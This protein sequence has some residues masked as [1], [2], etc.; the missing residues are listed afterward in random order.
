MADKYGTTGNDLLLG[1]TSD[2]RLIGKGGLDTLVG[3]S[4]NDYLE[5]GEGN[6]YLAGGAGNDILE[7][8]TGA[9]VLEGGTGDDKYYIDSLSDQIFENAGAGIDSVFL[10]LGSYTMAA[11]LENAY[12][13]FG[14]HSVLT[15]NDLDNAIYMGLG[16]DTVYGGGG[17]DF[18]I[19][20]AGNDVIYGGAGNDVLNGGT[21]NNWLIGGS[22]DDTYFVLDWTVAK[23]ETLYEAANE[24][25]DRV[26][27]QGRG[28]AAS[29]GAAGEVHS[30]VLSN[31]FEELAGDGNFAFNFKGNASDNV[32]QGGAYGDT[33]DGGT[34][35]DKMYGGAGADLYIVDNAGDTIY[36]ETLNYAAMDTARV[37][38]SIEWKVMSGVERV[39]IVVGNAT[40]TG[41]AFDDYIYGSSDNDVVYGGGGNDYI[42]GGGGTDWLA[43]DSGNDTLRTADS[44]NAST[45]SGGTGDDHFY[46]ANSSDLVIELADG[47]S[48]TVHLV[49][50]WV[51]GAEVEVA[52]V[53]STL[54][55][56]VTGN[57]GANLMY[58]GI[59]ADTLNG[60][61][62]NDQL[63]GGTG[64]DVMAGGAGDDSYWITST[65]DLITELAN[66][67]IDTV[68][69]LIS[70]GLTA[71]V[72]NL[73]L[74]WLAT[75]GT[76]NVL[77]NQINGSFGSQT[78]RGMAGAD[79]IT[80]SAGADVLFGGAGADAFVFAFGDNMAQ[81]GQ[82]DTISDFV[83]GKDHID[84]TA[85]DSMA[86]TFLGTGAFTNQLGEMRVEAMT[87]GV[88]LLID[89][90][91]DG[92]AD[93][94]IDLLGLSGLSLNDFML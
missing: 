91:G 83:R 47:G 43:G 78:L 50:D 62:G 2:D 10:K 94:A 13:S 75:W 90:T 19:G 55:V 82:H 66:D 20:D 36:F 89:T 35:A 45:L 18:I 48:D 73:S 52:Y 23:V 71:N 88:Q 32:L 69:S 74:G 64:A 72:E 54:G 8:G 14:G 31:N 92:A 87:G 26:L 1:T 5:G 24:G 30:F 81:A 57:A 33:L 76:G 15:G 41:S 27:T 34:G 3:N 9:D 4:G 79:T 61:Q 70:Y 25:Y 65:S 11:N 7:G 12:M 29:T 60:G 77:A 51:M 53:E 84:L 17:N 6:D 22:G 68:Q 42:H 16:N 67:G 85:M 28:T 58:G 46:L 38:A 86:L 59:G 80:G 56:N 21:G 49:K 39:D 63:D 40:I 44:A 93:M 37:T